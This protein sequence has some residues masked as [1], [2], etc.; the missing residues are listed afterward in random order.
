MSDVRPYDELPD[1]ELIA[2]EYALGVLDPAERAAAARRIAGDGAFARLVEAWE[3]RLAPWAGEIAEVAPPPAVWERIAAALPAPAAE[4]QSLW[5]SLPFWRIFALAS[6][7]AAACLAV[8]VYFGAIGGGQGALVASIEGSNNRAFVATIDATRGT[9]AVIP[10]AYVADAT[11]V[12][13]LWIIPADGKPRSMGLL[14]ADK[15]V[16]LTLSPELARFARSNVL[17]AVSLEPPGGS[18]TG[19]PTGPVIASGKLTTL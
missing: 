9:V 15:P 7:L 5:E 16:M 13:E 10:A 2:A 6:A 19:Q 17:L 12:P 11:R 14:R 4:R 3:R 8:A 1:D 18:P